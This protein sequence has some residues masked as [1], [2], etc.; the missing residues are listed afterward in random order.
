MA[1]A[2]LVPCGPEVEDRK[3]GTHQRAQAPPWTE[4]LPLPRV[5]RHGT[6]GRARCDRRQPDPDRPL[7]GCPA[8]LSTSSER[9]ANATGGRINYS[10]RLT[11]FVACAEGSRIIHFA[12]ESN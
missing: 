9:D 5:P 3:R 2:A 6:L 8:R 12:T 11:V 4:S 10:N 1:K 7:P